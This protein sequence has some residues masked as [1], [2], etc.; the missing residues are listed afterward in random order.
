MVFTQCSILNRESPDV[1]EN[2]IPLVR[3]RTETI[4][5]VCEDWH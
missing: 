4:E 5:L 1:D 2:R 3:Q